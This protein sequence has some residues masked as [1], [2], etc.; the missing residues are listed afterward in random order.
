M[1][2]YS[3]QVQQL[4]DQLVTEVANLHSVVTANSSDWQAI[5]DATIA[6]E[7]TANSFNQA[8]QNTDIPPE[9]T[10]VLNLSNQLLLDVADVQAAI[11]A[12][13]SAKVVSTTDQV[14][15]TTSNLNRCVT[16]MSEYVEQPPAPEQVLPPWFQVPTMP[17]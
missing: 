4:T 3:E 14:V 15:L 16:A 5:D 8:I 6:V 11:T 7:T 12:N 1:S 9:N 17:M 10:M 2:I 13:D